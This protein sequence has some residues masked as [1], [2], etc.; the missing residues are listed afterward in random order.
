MADTVPD[1]TRECCV[2]LAVA[3]ARNPGKTGEGPGYGEI[4]VHYD[5]PDLPQSLNPPRKRADHQH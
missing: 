4:P 3:G 5:P 2:V 1:D